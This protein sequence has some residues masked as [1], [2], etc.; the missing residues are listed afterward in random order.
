MEDF[1][2]GDEIHIVLK[3]V[4]GDSCEDCIFYDKRHNVCYNPTINGLFDG[5]DCA[6]SVIDNKD[7]IFKLVSCNTKTNIPKGGEE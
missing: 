1:K 7:V 4:E 3:V 5:F 6:M 2:I